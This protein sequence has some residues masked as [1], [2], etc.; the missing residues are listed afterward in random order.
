M[1]LYEKLVGMGY[2]TKVDLC[3]LNRNNKTVISKYINTKHTALAVWDPTMQ[4]EYV[5]GSL[6]KDYYNALI[7]YFSSPEFVKAI[8]KAYAQEVNDDSTISH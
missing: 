5:A 6:V 1:H 3:V 4:F 7:N 2:E 8:K